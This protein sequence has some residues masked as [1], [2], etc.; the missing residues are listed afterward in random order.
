[1]TTSEGRVVVGVSPSL[2]GLQ[3]LR[4]AVAEAR[5]RGAPLVAVRAWYLRTAMFGP[6]EGQWREEMAAEAVHTL[7]SAFETAMGGV[8]AEVDVT[9]MVVGDRVDVALLAAAHRRSDVLVLGGRSGWPMS[10]IVK[11]C[12]RKANCAVVVVPPPELA[13]TASRRVAVRA[14]LRDVEQYTGRG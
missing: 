11:Q 5:R 6:E 10:W 9:A 8:P 4:Y 14:L 3:A 1:M 7:R 12:V 13:R 2:G